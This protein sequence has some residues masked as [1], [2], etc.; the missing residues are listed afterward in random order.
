MATGKGEIKGTTNGSCM[1]PSGSKQGGKTYDA[2]AGA[3]GM[4]QTYKQTGKPGKGSK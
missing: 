1:G 2:S 4:R 3:K